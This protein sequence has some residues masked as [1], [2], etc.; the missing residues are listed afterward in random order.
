MSEGNFSKETEIQIKKTALYGCYMSLLQDLLFNKEVFN[1]DFNPPPIFKKLE[2]TFAS[3]EK[4][5]ELKESLRKIFARTNGEALISKEEEG[6]LTRWYGLKDGKPY[7]GISEGTEKI[8]E[9][10][11]LTKE[12]VNEMK[13]TGSL[14]LRESWNFNLLPEEAKK[15]ARF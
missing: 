8:A 14:K 5:D 11:Y 13:T 15:I 4:F 10:L 6:V 3:P 9:E 2:N 12:K 7:Y 1:E